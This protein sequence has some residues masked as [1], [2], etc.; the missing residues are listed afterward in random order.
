MN[1]PKEPAPEKQVVVRHLQ[2]DYIS[3]TNT[4]SELITDKV[5]LLTFQITPENIDCKALEFC[6][7]A[8]L[9]GPPSQ[10]EHV[11][12]F[13]TDQAINN[14][15]GIETKP[16]VIENIMSGS[17]ITLFRIKYPTNEYSPFE[18]DQGKIQSLEILDAW[19]IDKSENRTPVQVLLE[20]N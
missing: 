18:G 2:T 19:I 3:V 8:T 14:T 4:E 10:Q 16:N 17:T 15:E 12:H 9:F 6:G 1:P 5:N 20:V 7:R 13:R 11:L